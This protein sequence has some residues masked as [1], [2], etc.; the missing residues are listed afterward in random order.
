MTQALLTLAFLAA[1][2]PAAWAGDDIGVDDAIKKFKKDM[3][4]PSAPARASAVT[5]LGATK[6]EKTAATLGG[7]LGTDTEPVRKAAALALGGFSDYKKQVTPMLVRGL[8]ANA[9]E[10]KVMEAIFQ[11]LSKLDDDSA[12][13][14]IHGFFE[15]KDKDVASA[16]LLA[17]AEI[18]NLSSIDLIISLM[19]KYEK[20]DAQAKNAGAG[21]SYGGYSVPNG[22]SD[23]K[24]AL[25]KAVLP[26]TVKAM[27][28][29][30]GEK[31]TTVKEWEIWWAKHKATFKIDK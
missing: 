24:A 8:N 5:E 1:S 13:P 12:L 23:P 15:D 30:S 14:A 10:P 2:L 17:A 21:A 4:N 11:G 6:S 16:A 29:I 25:A 7:L 26:A 28:M 22:G 18:R 19:K 31:W 9:K 20:I 27:Q 3:A